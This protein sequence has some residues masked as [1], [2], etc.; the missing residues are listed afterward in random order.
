[1]AMSA[2]KLK[3]K[4]EEIAPKSTLYRM[5]PAE[6]ARYHPTPVNVEY[7]A[8]AERSGQTHCL[9]VH[10]APHLSFAEVRDVIHAV[11]HIRD[12]GGR[13]LDEGRTKKIIQRGY[14]VIK[15][16][17]MITRIEQIRHDIPEFATAGLAPIELKESTADYL[18]KIKESKEGQ[19]PQ[20]GTN[21][22]PPQRY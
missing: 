22:R 1:M 19:G 21:R 4:L 3:R 13:A 5:S 11:E 17:K 8:D 20:G 16:P 7:A 14:I 12:K 18:D 6:L 2:E 15:E 10:L 9:F